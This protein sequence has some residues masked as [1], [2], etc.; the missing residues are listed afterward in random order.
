VGVKAVNESAVA[1]KK[2]P[3]F[4]NI[5]FFLSIALVF[6]APTISLYSGDITSSLV[7]L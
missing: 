6:S 4:A 2:T 7:V 5:L 1:K 3:S